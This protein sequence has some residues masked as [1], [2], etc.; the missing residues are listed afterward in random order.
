MISPFT[1]YL[2]MQLDSIGATVTFASV[3]T[4]VLAAVLFLF[5]SS[6]RGSSQ[7]YPDHEISKRQAANAD[8]LFSK[9][10]PAFVCASIFC[11]LSVLLPSSKT[12]AAMYVIP[13][14]ANSEA[15]QN[16]AGDLYEMAKQA[17][18]KLTADEAK[19]ADP[20]RHA[21]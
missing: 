5:A 20:D 13:A 12:A 10:K 1:V 7:S 4:G 9:V 15:V 8:R 11:A 19:P 6:E 18:R 21:R 16:E 14:I 17:M 3:I 2:V